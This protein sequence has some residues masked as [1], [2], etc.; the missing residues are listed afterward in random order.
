VEVS[1]IIPGDR[2][3]VESGW[4][5]RPLL[6]A[7]RK[8]GG[9]E[10]GFTSSSGGVRAQ[11]VTRKRNS[12]ARRNEKL[13]RT[14]SSSSGWFRAWANRSY[15]KRYPVATVDQHGADDSGDLKLNVNSP[16]ERRR[17]AGQSERS[18]REG[19]ES[20]AS[21]VKTFRKPAMLK[22]TPLDCE[23]KAT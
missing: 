9:A 23:T 22:T 8:I 1:V 10:A 17:K 12:A 16:K 5:T 3:K 21:F 15:P 18:G 20:Q 6:S 2:G 19:H 13:R 11:P 14:E 4:L 7:G